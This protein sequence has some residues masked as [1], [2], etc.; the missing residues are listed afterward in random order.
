MIRA[1]CLHKIRLFCWEFG[2]Q[3]STTNYVPDFTVSFSKS[4]DISGEELHSIS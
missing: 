3:K 4:Y 2:P 1:E